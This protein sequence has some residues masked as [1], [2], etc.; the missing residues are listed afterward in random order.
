VGE[1]K[2]KQARENYAVGI[3]MPCMATI[4]WQTALSLA[5]TTHL[6]A[7]GGVPINLHVVANSSLVQIARNVILENFLA[8][9]EHFLFWIDSDIVWQPAD[10]V[11]VLRLTKELGLVSGAYPI[12]RD[13]PECIINVTESA[14][15]SQHGCVA[16]DG[17]GLGFTCIRRDLIEAFAATKGRMYHA[18][19]GRMILDAFRVDTK[20]H[21]DGSVHARGE[22]GAFFD[23]MRALGH[24]AWLDPTL[25][26]GH[27][28]AK[29]YRV[30]MQEISQPLALA[31]A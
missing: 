12:K 27:V 25:S 6:A 26:L 14:P 22:D 15:P 28:G 31:A 2:L 17:M 3:G 11:R 29:E 19:N 18:G 5:R 9:Q 7:A 10:F 30:E 1:A 13:P 8:G 4:P 20:T 21:A 24:Q 16:I 23:D